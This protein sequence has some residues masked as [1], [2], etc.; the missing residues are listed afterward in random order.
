MPNPFTRRFGVL[1]D[2]DEPFEFEWDREDDPTQSEV[3]DLWKQSL[4]DQTIQIGK[5]QMEPYEEKG[6]F[7]FKTPNEQLS[8]A[9]QATQTPVEEP[10]MLG[11]AWNAATT[12]FLPERKTEN[13]VYGMQTLSRIGDYAYEKIAR[14]TASPVG[15]AAAAAGAFSIPARIGLAGIG[16]ATGGYSALE[17]IPEA[18]ADPTFENIADVGMDLTGV[19]APYLGWKGGAFSKKPGFDV[20]GA[21]VDMPPT[22]DVTQRR[23]YSDSMGGRGLQLEAQNPIHMPPVEEFVP[24]PG[25][26]SRLNVPE[27]SDSYVKETTNLGS[28]QTERIFPTVGGVGKSNIEIM[29]PKT[30]LPYS[31]PRYED[32]VGGV[33][34]MGIRGEPFFPAI[35]ERTQ[36]S[37]NQEA[38]RGVTEMLERVGKQNLKKVDVTPVK[39]VTSVVEDVPNAS[40]ETFFNE[41]MLRERA[42]GLE[43][44]PEVVLNPAESLRLSKQGN[45]I[46]NQGVRVDPRTGKVLGPD[47][48]NPLFVKNPAKPVEPVIPKVETVSE[49]KGIPRVAPEDM[50]GGKHRHEAVHGGFEVKLGKIISNSKDPDIKRAA[51]KTAAELAANKNAAAVRGLRGG[52][53]SGWELLKRQG[54][55]GERASRF[56][57]RVRADANVASGTVNDKYRAVTKDVSDKDFANAMSVARGEAGAKLD[58]PELAPVVKAIQRAFKETDRIAQR[59]G[60]EMIDKEGKSAVTTDNIHTKDGFHTYVHEMVSK[61]YEAEHFGVKALGDA[62]SPL[63]QIIAQTEN[64]EQSRMIFGKQLGKEKIDPDQ[65]ALA[66]KLGGFEAAT[67]LT[68]HV[69]NNF[70]G[71]PA[72]GMRS[73]VK[74]FGKALGQTMRGVSAEDTGAINS[75]MR[76][77]LA[78]SA[79][80]PWMQGIAK[81]SGWNWSEKFLRNWAGNAGKLDSERLFAQLKKDPKNPT[82]RAKLD[83]LLLEDI[84]QVAKQDK[85]TPEQTK[86]AGYRMAELSQ[87]L[88]DGADLPPIW[89]DSPLYRIPL[90]FKRYAFDTS[91]NLKNLW[92]S[93]QTP[94]DK[95][96]MLAKFVTL[97][98]ATGEL[99]GDT[100]T[101]IRAGIQGENPLEAIKERGA[102]DKSPNAMQKELR[103]FYN[104]NGIN[105]QMVNRL[106]DDIGGSYAL[107]LVGQLA[108]DATDPMGQ[109]LVSTIAGPAIGDAAGVI[110]G[111]V[112]SVMQ[113]DWRPAVKAA[114]RHL[115]PLGYSTSKWLNKDKKKKAPGGIGISPTMPKVG[116]F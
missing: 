107:G 85:L 45:V 39:S 5:E 88:V 18:I 96:A 40:N 71:A 1:M 66:N 43:T 72:I 26:V 24:P 64:P 89:S 4:A 56:G 108:G 70:G 7:A 57:Q 69:I 111:G 83:D 68:M 58:K 91:R 113:E 20:L 99:L 87:G 80:S 54:P 9:T 19:A 52:I 38:F 31:R 47:P 32:R 14:P 12:S 114:V 95:A 84:D 110:A 76:A 90:M 6:P 78:E 106:L 62:S 74:N 65:A 98:G 105:E 73:S 112:N 25:P 46:A 41:Q 15:V 77:A 97:Y 17:D 8:T 94:K 67:K 48:E 42:A 109:R 37:S 86:R 34:E 30:G 49:G 21:D 3:R 82:A 102:P 16:A 55:G 36:T 50:P 81:K 59:S 28:G 92:K 10:G 101:G 22:R 63:R 35:P 75:T 44:L 23:L 79:D 11:K 27:V 60:M 93:N 115:T 100:T 116:G 61:A 53:T 33:G 13:P 103:K 51:Q 104:K 2:N 29:N